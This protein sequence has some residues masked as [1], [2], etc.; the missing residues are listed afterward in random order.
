MKEKYSSFPQWFLKPFTQT[1]SC[2]KAS[3][4]CFHLKRCS[5]FSLFSV[6]LRQQKV[7]VIRL[8]FFCEERKRNVK[9]WLKIETQNA[10]KRKQ[11]TFYV[12]AKSRILSKCSVSFTMIFLDC[13]HYV[14][15]LQLF[16]L[17][18]FLLLKIV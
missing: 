15:K 4:S 6:L 12:E 11:I 7:K 1:N 16:L 5:F 17:L 14:L 3:L 10:K 18:S 8:I 2:L 13:L 9:S